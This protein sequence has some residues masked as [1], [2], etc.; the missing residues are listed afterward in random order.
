MTLVL[1]LRGL[2]V[3]V[4][5]VISVKLVTAGNAGYGS[6]PTLPARSPLLQELRQQV[7]TTQINPLWTTD[8]NLARLIVET[9]YRVDKAVRKLRRV[10]NKFNFHGD[11]YANIDRR[12]QF[13][14]IARIYVSTYISF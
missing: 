5:T 7:Q 3:S 4:F 12:N 9:G 11:F 10:S 6:W 13:N 1:S 14:E 8:K 2:V